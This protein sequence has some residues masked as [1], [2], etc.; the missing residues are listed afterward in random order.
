MMRLLVTGASGFIGKNFLLRAPKDWKITGTFLNA[1]DFPDFIRSNNLENI[2]AERCNLIDPADV[3]RFV[4][5]SGN[6]FDA[7]LYLAAN[8]NPGYSVVNPLS[9]LNSNTTGLI[10]VLENIR[11][12]RFVYISSGA[13][14]DGLRGIVSPSSK[15]ISTLPYAISKMASERY[16]QFYRWRR[17]T[18]EEYVIL[19]FFGAFGPYEPSRKIFSRL[20]NSIFFEK[21]DEFIIHGDGKNYIDAM[22]VEDAITGIISVL[23]SKEKDIIVDFACCKP[24]TL[25]ELCTCVGRCLGKEIKVAFEGEVAEY[26]TFYASPDEMR[27][28]FGFEVRVP[29]EEG[30]KKMVRHMEIER[31]RA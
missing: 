4:K 31:G 25:T 7:V 26:I 14:Y 12:K 16:V 27:R 8:G 28:R 21:K 29:L 20:I 19:R 2:T 1:L 6:N 18:I 23:R 11:C 30:I 22:Y 10:N 5:K 24:I 15:L 17:R 9:D 3:N 13:V